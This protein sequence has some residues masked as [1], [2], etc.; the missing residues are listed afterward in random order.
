MNNKSLEEFNEECLQDP[1]VKKAVEL[2]LNLTK[3]E[4]TS[5][6]RGALDDSEIPYTIRNGEWM[7]KKKYYAVRKGR[8][9]GVFDNWAECEESVL[10][11]S[12]SEYK[13]FKTKE[14]A[15]HYLKLKDKRKTYPKHLVTG[16]KNN[17]SAG[18]PVGGLKVSDIYYI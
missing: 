9:I 5:I 15:Q 2:D 4:A 13:G 1:E 14:G 8:T 6:L 3:E 7:S 17:P 11:F 10:G 18:I 16:I 12:G